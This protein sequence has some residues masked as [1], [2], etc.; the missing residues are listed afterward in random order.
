MD[1]TP[2]AVPDLTAQQSIKLIKLLGVRY[3][4][5]KDRAK[6][7]CEMFPTAAQNK[8]WL[9]D[10]LDKL[11]A[12]ARDAKDTFEDVPFDFRHHKP[13]PRHE[14]PEEWKMTGERRAY[15][16]GKRQAAEAKRVEALLPG[17]G[18]HQLPL[19]QSDADKVEVPVMAGR[20]ADVSLS[21]F[22]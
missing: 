20:E 15:L 4:P 3:N 21:R 2:S 12:E 9:G 14:F 19:P 18:V 13:K 11:L 22:P 5:S 8:R 7:S 17:G 16:D 6:M 1:F 10:T